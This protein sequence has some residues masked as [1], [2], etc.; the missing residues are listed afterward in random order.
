MRVLLFLVCAPLFATTYCVSNSGSDSNSGTATLPNC[1]GVVSAWQTIAKVNAQTFS[2]GDSILFQSGGIWRELLSVPSGSTGASI[3]FSSYG[4]TVQPIIAGSNLATSWSS[5]SNDGSSIFWDGFESGNTSAWTS[6]TDTGSK[7]SVESSIVLDGAFSAKITNANTTAS[8]VKK[9][10]VQPTGTAWSSGFLVKP[11]A[12]FSIAAASGTCVQIGELD[13]TSWGMIF[14][15]AICNNGSG[16]FWAITRNRPSFTTLTTTTAVTPGTTYA[17]VIT[18]T[19]IGSS[20]LGT[21]GMTVNGVSVYSATGLDL[22]STQAE[23]EP[24]TFNLGVWSSNAS[25]PA[26]NLYFDDGWVGLTANA[27]VPNTWSSS[28]S[29]QPNSVYFNAVR[30]TPEAS[31]AAIVADKQWFW[32]ASKLYAFGAVNPNTTYPSE[33]EV[34][35]RDYAVDVELSGITLSG[36]QVEYANQSGIRVATYTSPSNISNDTV[37]NCTALDNYQHG[38]WSNTGSFN[39]TG[40]TFSRNVV[41]GNGLAGIYVDAASPNTITNPY[42]GFNSATMNAWRT[43]ILEYAGIDVW[44]QGAMGLIVEYNTSFNNNPTVS[45]NTGHGIHITQGANGDVIRYNTVYSNTNGIDLQTESNALAYFNVSYSNVEAGIQV[46]NATVSTNGIYQNTVYGNFNGIIVDSFTPT[47]GG[48][49]NNLIKN[50]LST[51]NT[52]QQFQAYNGGENDGTNGSGNV[53]TYNGFGPQASNFIQWAASTNYSTYSAWES[54]AGNCGTPGCS[55]SMQSNPLF[56]NAVSGDFRL[57]SGSPAIAAGVFI[58]GVST[59]NPPNIGALGVV[60]PSLLQGASTMAGK[61]V[62]Q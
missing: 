17:V 55:H 56:V 26:G 61:T 21:Y 29:T 46:E 42:V 47:A 13:N 49:T 3:I 1:T 40:L 54:A 62:T 15:P 33:I 60:G 14:Q 50:N 20:T 41:I 12:S 11:D 52:N 32:S 48:V 6:L 8:Y 36:I 2:P 27:G 37:T 23:Y 4:G 22:S 38:I 45:H 30:G 16:L 9:T 59:S 44:S 24:D 10:I 18:S 51:G 58:S 7:F 28:I 31:V 34:P 39:L 57:S 5:N 43:D 25:S 53:Y 19:N 35:Q